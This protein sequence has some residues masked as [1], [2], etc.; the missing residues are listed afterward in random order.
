MNAVNEW[1]AKPVVAIALL[2][3]MFCCGAA[4]AQAQAAAP[5]AAGA[6]APGLKLTFTSNGV[7]DSRPAR[8]IALSVP[9]N[10]PPTPFL[11]PGAFTATWE[12]LVNLRIRGE[13]TFLPVGA[14]GVKVLIG[15]KLAL[16]TSGDDFTKV[17][18]EPVKLTKGKNRIRVEYTSPERGDAI[19]RL[20]WSE[21]GAA[22]PV[23]PGVLTHDA[24]DAGLRTKLT[25]H[26]GRALFGELRCVRCHVDPYP[27]AMEKKLEGTGAMI[28]PGMP[29]LWKDAPDLS[30]AGARLSERW[31]AAWIANPRALNPRAEMPRLFKDPQPAA[32][33]A[34]YL[35]TLAIP[36]APDP[37]D[38]GAP[39]VVSG[40]RLYA[41]LGCI[42]CHTPP[43]YVGADPV[44]PARIPH[45]HV[46]EKYTRKSLRS[47]LKKP[48]A[49][50]LFVRMPDF[51]LTDAEL[52]ALVTYL[53]R[54]PTELLLPMPQGDVD[55]GKQLFAA[56]GCLNCHG[57]LE[58]QPAVRG[59]SLA[60]LGKFKALG[61]CLAADPASRKT[62][63]DFTLTQ[64]QRS[65][66][67]EFVAG[68]TTSLRRESS[69]EFAERQYVQLNCAAC[70]P[71][72]KQDDVWSGLSKEIDALFPGH[73]SEES[74][75]K[76]FA[77]DQSRPSLTWIGEKL[78]PE[79]MAQFV[80]GHVQYKPRPWLRARM[81]G[82]LAG[83]TNYSL[84]AEGFALEHGFPARSPDL[85]KPD[86]ELAEV[87][88]KLTGKNGGFS[89]VQCH[90]VGAQ[91]ALAPFEAPAPNFAYVAERLRPEYFDR[92]MMKPQ[93]VLPGTR[94]PDFA[95]SEGKTALKNVF[96]GDARKQFDSIWNYLLEG[97]KIQPPP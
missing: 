59:A 9:A 33:I 56:T 55:R 86:Q 66:L 70:H 84:I 50:F 76:Q 31:M 40:A 87:G 35:A 64:D 63:P 11:Q 85:P 47:F 65:A 97:T 92:W 20:Y 28:T 36:I 17:K 39:Q 44:I 21:R 3:G 77:P 29:E 46:A 67:A 54:K 53:Y 88:R 48:N 34:A 96:D 14:G 62:G 73:A 89:C 74:N 37:R 30:N 72:D 32:D 51:R 8:L 69:I 57:P 24:S 58:S 93:R 38:S 43:D 5:A 18:S 2:L 23:P 79:W 41:N 1:V 81:P 12:G 42:A 19:F 25:M 91:K 45:E 83:S 49:N 80:S 26:E 68:D 61:G 90:A 22:E 94:M 60:E 16:A 95:D 10:T 7:M 82:F 15:E 13:Y 6:L 27:G 4:I 71:R 52:D 75:G 78:R